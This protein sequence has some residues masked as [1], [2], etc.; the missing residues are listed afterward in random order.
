MQPCSISMTTS[1]APLYH[2]LFVLRLMLVI[3]LFTAFGLYCLLETFQLSCS[4]YKKAFGCTSWCF[5]N[6]ANVYFHGRRGLE[7]I[8]FSKCNMSSSSFIKFVLG[9]KS[10]MQSGTTLSKN[11]RFL[12]KKTWACFGSVHNLLFEKC[13]KI[14]EL[15]SLCF[16]SDRRKWHRILCFTGIKTAWFT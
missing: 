8:P 5:E 16:S 11:H 6:T 15:C 2:C 9:F 10:P 14:F 1:S 4:A 3:W 7:W 13:I 12:F